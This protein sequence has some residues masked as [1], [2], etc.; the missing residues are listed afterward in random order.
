[1]PM[2]V[3]NVRIMRMAMR[4]GLVLMQVSMR[5]CAI[6]GDGV[7]MLMVF[8]VHVRVIVVQRLVGMHMVVAFREVKPDA[9]RHQHGRNPE[10]SRG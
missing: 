7:S 8:V 5:F 2:L 3:M 10:G 4:D 6:P 9:R 1:M